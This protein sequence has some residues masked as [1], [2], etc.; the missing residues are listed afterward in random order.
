M[1]T[2]TGESPIRRPLSA[3]EEDAIARLELML[4]RV[5]ALQRYQE[6]G[7]LPADWDT[8]DEMLA[9][10]DEHGEGEAGQG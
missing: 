8:W 3:A 5:Q 7:E 6:T 4:S 9:D 2:T 1:T 10:P